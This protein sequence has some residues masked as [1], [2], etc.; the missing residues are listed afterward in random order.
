MARI[1]SRIAVAGL[2]LS[3]IIGGV[4]LAFLVAMFAAFAAGARSTGMTLGLVN[5]IT[6][7]VTLPLALPGV[8]RLHALV[9]PRTGAAADALLLVGIGAGGTI[10]VLQV[11]LVAGAVPFE[12]QIGP[13]SVAFLVLAIYFVLYGRL[14]ARSGIVP[15]GTRLGVLAATYAGYPIW[16]FRIARSIAGDAAD[17]APATA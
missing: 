11:L 14:A 13:V 12:R 2:R 15:G 16:A 1:D 9:R 8:L 5:D 17:T 4:G 10:V 3:G 6:G 7:V